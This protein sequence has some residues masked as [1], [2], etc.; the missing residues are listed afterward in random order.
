VGDQLTVADIVGGDVLRMAV[1]RAEAV[2]GTPAIDAYI[3]SL[4]E[5]PARQRAMARVERA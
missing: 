1:R 3:D 5:R 2:S 4:L